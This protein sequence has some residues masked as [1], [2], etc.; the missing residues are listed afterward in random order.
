MHHNTPRGRGV[1][2]F[3]DGSS[4]DFS[5]VSDG[6]SN[7]IVYSE[8]SMAGELTTSPVSKF[9]KGH[10]LVANGQNHMTG[11]YPATCAGL[12]TSTTVTADTTG[13]AIGGRLFDAYMKFAIFYT[14]LPP[15]YPSCSAGNNGMEGGPTLITASSYH[16]GGVNVALL[17]GA[18]RFASETMDAGNSLLDLSAQRPGVSTADHGYAQY[19]TGESTWGVWGAM[20]TTHSG[21][22]KSL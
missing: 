10:L 12:K 8:V 7:T 21:E 18:V 19:L 5:A 2:R 3:G 13:N 16:M 6:L 20:G 14:V 4:I 15:N 11:I 1:F 17:D 22:S 9:Y